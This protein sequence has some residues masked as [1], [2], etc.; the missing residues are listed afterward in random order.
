MNDPVTLET[1]RSFDKTMIIQ[2][3][4]AMRGAKD[5][6]DNDIPLRCPVNLVDLS[7]EFFIPNKA[8]KMEI[9]A[10]YETNPWAFDFNPKV[11][12]INI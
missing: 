2:Y 7:G 8:L 10:F 9:E 12:W 3:F 6:E 11:P 4:E 5:M 1:G